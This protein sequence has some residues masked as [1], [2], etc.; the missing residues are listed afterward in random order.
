MRAVMILLVAFSASCPFSLGCSSVPP[1]PPRALQLNQSGAAALAAGDLATAEARL[2]VAIEYSPRFTEAWVNLGYV[3]LRRGEL[4]LAR[5]DFVKAR[6]LNPDIAAP[7]HALGV[8]ADQRDLGREAEGHY[9]QALKVDPGFAPS[10][11]N[12]ARRLFGRG[13]LDEACEQFRRLT[14]VAPE[15]LLGYLGLAEC[16]LRL[17]RDEEADG[18][19]ARARGRFGEVPELLMLVA[20]QL[21]RRDAFAEAEALLAPLTDDERRPRSAEAWAWIAVSRLARRD[22]RGAREAARESL[23]IDPT[24]AVAKSVLH[25]S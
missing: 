1:L 16:L 10:R 13:D 9:R 14:Q 15:E 22:E 12:L 17:H 5:K 7:H 20:R 25:A 11:A 2:S 6:D 3:A 23:A 4:A 8:L 18:V 24:N 21:L 19:I